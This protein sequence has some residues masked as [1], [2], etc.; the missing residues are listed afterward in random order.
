MDIKPTRKSIRISDFDYSSPGSYFVTVCAVNRHPLFWDHSGGLSNIGTIIDK[1]INDISSHYPNISVDKY[2]IMPDHIH[3][4][5]TINMETGGRLIAAPT[6]STV[7]GQMKRT[8]SKQAGFPVWQKSFVDRV[9][10]NEKGYLDVWE[11]IENN[12]IKLDSAYD[13]IDFSSM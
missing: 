10:R 6:L 4:L 9:I 1:A 3:L 13:K 7:V 12:P 11:Y 8:V 2:C 5:I